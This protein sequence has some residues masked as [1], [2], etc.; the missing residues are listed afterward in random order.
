MP[1]GEGNLT[2]LTRKTEISRSRLVRLLTV[3]STVNPRVSRG[4]VDAKNSTFCRF[5]L[6]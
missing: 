5:F 4:V 1:V 6:I 2:V 3:S